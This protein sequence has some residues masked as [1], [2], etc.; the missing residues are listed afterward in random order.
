MEEPIPSQG[1]IFVFMPSINYL[2]S[3][4]SAE[5]KELYSPFFN[6]N[7]DKTKSV[8]HLIYHSVPLEVILNE[9]YRNFME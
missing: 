9:K 4:L 1:F 2:D 8:I 6:S 7:C 5:N 3:F